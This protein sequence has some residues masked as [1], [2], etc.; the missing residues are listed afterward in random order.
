MIRTKA[1]KSESLTWRPYAGSND[2]QISKDGLIA[3][4]KTSSF[5]RSLN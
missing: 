1:L 2:I 3:T 5:D 4:K